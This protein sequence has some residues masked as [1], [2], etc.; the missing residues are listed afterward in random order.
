MLIKDM[1]DCKPDTSYAGNRVIP[2]T[3]KTDTAVAENY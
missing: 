1:A 2:G 3:K